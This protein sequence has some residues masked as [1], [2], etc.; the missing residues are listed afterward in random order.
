MNGSNQCEGV[1]LWCESKWGCQ[2][3]GTGIQGGPQRAKDNPALPIPG[4]LQLT[5]AR[6]EMGRSEKLSSVNPKRFLSAGS[7]YTLML[8]LHGRYGEAESILRTVSG[9]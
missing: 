6:R 8:T 3:P 5:G 4:F 1:A 7:S 9:K 2:G